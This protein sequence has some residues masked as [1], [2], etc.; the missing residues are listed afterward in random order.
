MSTVLLVDDTPSKRYVLASWL[1]R[2]G[3]TV[4]EAATGGLALERFGRDGAD[5][6]FIEQAACRVYSS[7]YDIRR[8]G[9]KTDSWYGLAI[10]RQYFAFGCQPRETPG[11]LQPDQRHAAR[12][13]EKT[14]ECGAAG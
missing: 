3:Y 14:L 11:Q 5:A 7:Y 10:A 9:C 6:S 13:A 2:G 4:I 1:R 12:S 8:G